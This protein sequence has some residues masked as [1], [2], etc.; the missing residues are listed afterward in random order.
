MPAAPPT[1]LRRRV[2]GVS[3]PLLVRLHRLPRGVVPVLTVVLV[4]VGVLAPPA[5]GV[6][7]LALVALFV[8]WIAYLSWPAVGGGGRLVRVGMVALVVALA[9]SRL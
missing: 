3:R 1:A 4:A 7:A 2:E 8:A 6:V 9:A 5:L